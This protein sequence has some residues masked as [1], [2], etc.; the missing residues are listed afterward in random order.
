MTCTPLRDLETYKI[1]HEE[2]REYVEIYVS[3]FTRCILVELGGKT[4]L[5]L[6]V[7]PESVKVRRDELMSSQCISM[8]SEEV[9]LC[10]IE[11]PSARI[12]KAL[13]NYDKVLSAHA[14]FLCYRGLC[15]EIQLRVV[16]EGEL[17]QALSSLCAEDLEALSYSGIEL[18]K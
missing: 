5:S 13:S 7:Y 4:F 10:V 11:L 18:S 16:L 8:E 14:L 2:P 1:R 9:A 3:D 6:D 15:N 17:Q 12:A